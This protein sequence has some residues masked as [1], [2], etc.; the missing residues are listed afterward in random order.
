MWKMLQNGS[1][2]PFSIP[3]SRFIAFDLGIE[4]LTPNGNFSRWSNVP[5]QK[6]RDG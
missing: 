5:P 1:R 6:S 2:N 3:P 4:N